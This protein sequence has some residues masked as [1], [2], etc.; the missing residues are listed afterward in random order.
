MFMTTTW[1]RTIRATLDELFRVP[2]RPAQPKPPA[3]ADAGDNVV[4]VKRARK[5]TR[6]ANDPQAGDAQ[7]AVPKPRAAR[8]AKLKPAGALPPARIPPEAL[9][10]PNVDRRLAWTFGISLAIHV[11]VLSIHFAPNVVK[12]FGRSTP[13]EVALVNAKSKDK[14]V[15]ADVL[16]Q[17]NLDGGGNTDADRRAKS[18]LPV[19]PRDSAQNE[20]S[21][22]TQKVDELETDRAER[23]L[24]ELQYDGSLIAVGED[25][26]PVFLR[27]S[28]LEAEGFD[29]LEHGLLAHPDA[30]SK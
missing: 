24:L 16:A 28:F 9:R 17:A 30:Q 27:R 22:A 14:P 6:V 29:A 25:P 20:I 3:P 18:P 26:D 23:P 8:T 19:L 13:L 15:K 11:I 12:D 7:P 5:S 2:R 1:G 21:V 10:K 4:P